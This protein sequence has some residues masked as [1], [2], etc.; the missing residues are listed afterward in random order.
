MAGGRQ[1]IP[2][3]KKKLKAPPKDDQDEFFSFF[4]GSITGGWTLRW[5]RS[6]GVG[7]YKV[8]GVVSFAAP[9][10]SGARWPIGNW[11]ACVGES[12]EPVYGGARGKFDA[13][14]GAQFFLANP[15]FCCFLLH[16]AGSD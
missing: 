5:R 11:A 2:Q 10:T 8:I 15:F 1:A 3:E 14:P 9:G 13:D 6:R 4:L 7:C 12:V 16:K